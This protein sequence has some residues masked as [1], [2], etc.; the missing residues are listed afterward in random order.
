MIP[1]NERVQ[2]LGTLKRCHTNEGLRYLPLFVEV[3]TDE[4]ICPECGDNESLAMNDL[5][6]LCYLLSDVTEG[7]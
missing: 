7:L 4:R 5:C 1:T 3:G 2:W 6:P